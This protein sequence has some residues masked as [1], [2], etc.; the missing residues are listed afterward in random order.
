MNDETN[1]V[2]CK[3]IAKKIPS[4]IMF[5]NGSFF[6]F[7]DATPQAPIH[8]LVVPK[9]HIADIHSMHESDCDMIGNLF[10]TAKKIA[11][12]LGLEKQG[13]R[14]VINNGEGAGQSVFHL[15]LHILSGRSFSWPPG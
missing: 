7:A 9:K 2:F 5:E 12:D 3:I 8:I 15:H 10:L 1:C 13:Y 11:S 6:A 4:R 14:L